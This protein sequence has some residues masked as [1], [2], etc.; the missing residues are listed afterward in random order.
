MA[1]Y[2][3]NTLFIHIPKTGGRWI[4]EVITKH[5]QNHTIY[6][7]PIYDA[8][9]CPDSKGKNVFTFIRH[10]ATFCHSLWHHRAKKKLNKFGHKFNWQNY[11]RLEKDCQSTDYDTFMNNVAKNENVVRDY[12]KY[13]T[14]RYENIVFGKMENLCQSFIEILKKFNEEFDENAIRMSGNFQIGKGSYKNLISQKH[15]D[16]ICGSEKYICEKFKYSNNIN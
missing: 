15:V 4:K 1:I 9:A 5:V 6:G 7:D 10:P 14:D 11:I 8:H 2:L 16:A 3:K 12:Y 13:Y